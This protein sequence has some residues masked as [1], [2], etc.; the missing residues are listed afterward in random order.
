M[1]VVQLVSDTDPESIVL[2]FGK[3]GSI[4]YLFHF[5]NGWYLLSMKSSEELDLYRT[6]VATT[7]LKRFS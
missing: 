1:F 5:W 7:A 6:Y 2:Q 3:V 4:L